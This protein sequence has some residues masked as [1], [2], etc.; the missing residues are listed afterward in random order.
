MQLESPISS[1]RSNEFRAEKG[2]VRRRGVETACVFAVLA[3]CITAAVIS[4]RRGAARLFSSDSIIS[5]SI[6]SANLAVGL[7]PGDPEIRYLRSSLLTSLGDE[8]AAVDEVLN[9]LEHRPNDYFLW[10]YLGKLRESSGDFAG[11]ETAF[12]RSVEFAPHYAQPHWR[13]G[14]L[15]FRL[16]RVES[17]FAELRA[18]AASDQTLYGAISEMAWAVAPGRPD[19]I[20]RLVGREDNTA[21]FET[22]CLLARHGL[23]R[24]AAHEYE[25]IGGLSETQREN[26]ISLLADTGNLEDAFGIWRKIHTNTVSYGV[27]D[28]DFDK[29]FVLQ[30]PVFGWRITSTR[31]VEV[32]SRR[33]EIE[34]HGNTL[35]ID[36]RGEVDSDKLI[37]WQLVP[38]SPGTQYTM[39]FEAGTKELNSYAMPVILVQDSSSEVVLGTISIS[40]RTSA[41]QRYQL[42]FRTGPDSHGVKIGVTR[43][44]CDITPCPIFGRLEADNFRLERTM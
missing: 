12:R 6:G 43:A 10:L 31:N 4:V 7:A 11:A 21:R 30:P 25:D 13:L 38:V 3:L 36:W 34:G 37:V 27:V 16:G 28:G 41:W 5:R 35:T 23:G 33:S 19:D 44:R 24:E 26:F 40:E 8:P 32:S 22:I 29:G 42:S 14:N 18:A 20:K 15:L 1:P 17:A 2:S 39:N 9:A